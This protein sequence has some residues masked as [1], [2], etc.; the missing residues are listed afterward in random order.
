MTDLLKTAG[1]V[2]VFCLQP[3]IFSLY[4]KDGS[5]MATIDFSGTMISSKEL[6]EIRQAV[7]RLATY[8]GPEGMRFLN[9]IP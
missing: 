9:D 2:E 8:I 4:S 5:Y 7:S 1:S 6:S 3:L